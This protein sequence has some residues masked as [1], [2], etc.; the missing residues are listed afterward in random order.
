MSLKTAIAQILHPFGDACF[1]LGRSMLPKSRRNPNQVFRDPRH[2]EDVYRRVF[3]SPYEAAALYQRMLLNDPY[4]EK[5]FHGKEGEFVVRVAVVAEELVANIYRLGY[6]RTTAVFNP[7]NDNWSK[8]GVANL[9]V[10][11][12]ID[13][14]GDMVTKSGIAFRPVEGDKKYDYFEPIE[15]YSRLL[16]KA[17]LEELSPVCRINRSAME[18]HYD[19]VARIQAEEKA[20][21]RLAWKKA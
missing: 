3:T 19:Q 13:E 10:I 14:V 17:E 9:V 18:R 15:S 5:L 12:E 2:L 11:R 20:R 7:Y 4:F 21:Q 1:Q 6:F 8:E 16:T